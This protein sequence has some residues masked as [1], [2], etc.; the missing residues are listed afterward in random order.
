MFLGG[1]LAGAIIGGGTALLFAP[2][3]GSETRD[4]LKSKLNDLEKE[5][6]KIKDKL[7]NAKAKAGE[8]KEEV[9]EKI[10]ES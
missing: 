4:Q 2:Q 9:K 5:M 10:K 7:I 6:N 1:I 8:V 3:K